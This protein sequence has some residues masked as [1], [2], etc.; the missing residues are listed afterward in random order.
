MKKLVLGT[1]VGFLALLPAQA[2]QEVGNTLVFSEDEMRTC[3]EEGGC[4]II[5]AKRLEDMLKKAGC[6]LTLAP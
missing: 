5:T 3:N 6:K 4:L 1:V 2:I